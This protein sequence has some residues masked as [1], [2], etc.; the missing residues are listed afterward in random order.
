MLP[1]QLEGKVVDETGEALQGYLIELQTTYGTDLSPRVEAI[2]GSD[3]SFSL[4]DIPEGEWR[5]RASKWG[6]QDGAFLMTEPILFSGGS[7]SLTF[8]FPVVEAHTLRISQGMRFIPASV[9]S[10]EQ[11]AEFEGV[12]LDTQTYAA[13]EGAQIE[14]FLDVVDGEKVGIVSVVSDANGRFTIESL[15][16]GLYYVSIMREGFDSVKNLRINHSQ[17]TIWKVYLQ[18]QNARRSA[19]IE[20][21][22]KVGHVFD[23]NGEPIGK[24]FSNAKRVDAGVLSGVVI[25]SGLPVGNQRLELVDSLGGSLNRFLTSQ[26]KADGTYSI[27][28]VEPGTYTLKIGRGRNAILV[29]NVEVFPGPN[30]MTIQL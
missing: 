27:M 19:V 1:S 25:S 16:S 20:R 6:V 29:P 22:P 24:V 26:T 14:L 2:S 18:D 8:S 3:G 17:P 5:V 10:N 30:E 4:K 12:V 28:G 23:G 21:R 9:I 11:T 7:K 13:I 15:A